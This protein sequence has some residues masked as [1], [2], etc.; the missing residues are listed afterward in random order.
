[1]C[2]VTSADLPVASAA[3]RSPFTEP[4]INPPA[5]WVAAIVLLNLGITSGWFGPIQ[6]LLLEQAKAISPDHKEAIASVVL[7]S[8]AAVSTVANPVWGALS[9]RTRLRM[10]R[11][12]PWA[13]A[14]V[15]GGAVSLLL[16]SQVQSVWAMVLGW[17]G[18][19]ATLN[20]GYAAVTA[21]VPDQVPVPKRGLI[22][23]L[24]A[25]AGTV[26]VLLGVQIAAWT[27][28]IAQG[29]VVIAIVLVVLSLPYLLGS[30]DLALPEDYRPP[31]FQLGAFLK[32]FWVSPRD[33]PDFAWAW[34][35]RFLVNL[36]NF[37]AL[38]Y[39]LYYLSDGL[40][41][42]DKEA[43]IRFGG[44]T[45]IYGVTIVLTAVLV[46]W[47]SDHVGRRKVFVIWSGIVVAVSAAILAL[48][49][50]WLA[51]VVAA[52]VLGA[53]YGI[54]QAV[55]FALITQVLP[56]A[57]ERAKDLGVINIA[58]ALPQVVAPAVVGVIITA[59]KA[60][61]LPVVTRGDGWSV[62]YGLVYL[63]AFVVSLLGAV[64]VTKI[65]SVR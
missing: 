19:Q 15:V 24:I 31:A 40:G 54:Y 9:D 56:G 65:R 44:L 38:S 23:G 63:V 25:V 43:A 41:F 29:Y 64:L 26:G 55:D 62:G 50:T 17:C 60:L 51:A 33:Y 32:G 49:Q 37:I 47:W 30:R 22:G 45:T 59:A 20:M 14:G 10:G 7:F 3:A 1:M 42:S 5:R 36:G 2:R 4:T 6:V 61:D 13:I 52:G 57:E 28:S 18:V 12:L 48:A 58:A 46:G 11:R 8:G 21:S 39:F 27:G 53:G 35:T 16:M 34:I